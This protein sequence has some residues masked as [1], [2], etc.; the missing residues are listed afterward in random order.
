MLLTEMYKKRL[1]L[2][3]SVLRKNLGT[4]ATLNEGVKQ[5]IAQVLRNQ[6]AYLDSK[7]INESFGAQSVGTQMG[8]IGNF[9]RFA[10]D[11]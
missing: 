9:K 2:S 7:K 6:S 11:L 1:A 4:D 3:E 10:L 5:A 8:D